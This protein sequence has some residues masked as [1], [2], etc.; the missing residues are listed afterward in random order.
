MSRFYEE[1]AEQ[2]VMSE[3]HEAL[4]TIYDFQEWTTEAL[5]GPTEDPVL[6]LIQLNSLDEFDELVED[7][8]T[9]LDTFNEELYER[10][11]DDSPFAMSEVEAL[12]MVDVNAFLK[13][14][15]LSFDAGELYL[16]LVKLKWCLYTEEEFQK[17]FVLTEHD[18]KSL[19]EAIVIDSHVEDSDVRRRRYRK[20]MLAL[21]II[22]LLTFV[23]AITLA[24]TAVILFTCR[25]RNNAQ[26]RELDTNAN[27]MIELDEYD[28]EDPDQ[29]P[30]LYLETGVMD[31]VED[32]AHLE[33]G[34]MDFVAC[35]EHLETAGAAAAQH[36]FSEGQI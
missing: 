21:T 4:E 22:A 29:N 5:T 34:V 9:S 8:H 1:T 17:L 35:Q 32:P 20:W 26:V 14:V 24:I 33:M 3:P 15:L 11:E 27:K 13:M 36:D 31:F 19:L 25:V 6:R 28:S 18:M 10:M 7:F 30:D 12:Q 2:G 23:A 16:N